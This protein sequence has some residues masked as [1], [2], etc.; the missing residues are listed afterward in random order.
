M[1]VLIVEKVSPSLRGLL[2]RWLIEVK[3]GVFVG[4]V[5]ALVR[6]RLWEKYLENLGKGAALQIWSTNNEQGFDMRMAGE[7]DRIIVDYEGL[8]LVKRKLSV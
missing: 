6:D 7:R 2:S 3:A 8:K 1:V 5:S 4:Q